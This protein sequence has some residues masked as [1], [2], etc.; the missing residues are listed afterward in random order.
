M[1]G[2]NEGFSELLARYRSACP[3]VEPSSDFMPRLWERIESTRSFSL[4]F[5]RLSRVLVTASAAVCLLLAILNILPSRA[6]GATSKFASYIDA[7]A[8]DTNVER[9]YTQEANRT[10]VEL[11][12]DIDK[13]P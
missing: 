4:M 10:P 6:V 11:P 8:A 5:Q 3:D 7:L 1:T 2:D 9:T 12:V 13:Q